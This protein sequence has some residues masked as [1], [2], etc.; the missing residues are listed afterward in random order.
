MYCF[1]FH[2][3]L[4]TLDTWIGR[5][6]LHPVETSEMELGLKTDDIMGALTRCDFITAV[7]PV[8]V[9][10][11]YWSFSIS[12]SLSKITYKNVCLNFIYDP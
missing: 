8:K 7:T 9:D 12:F 4:H 5:Q 2:R 6:G 10:S 3:L 1:Y 11:K